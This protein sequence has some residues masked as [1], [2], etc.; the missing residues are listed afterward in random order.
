[1]IYG[2]LQL[3]PTL[4]LAPFL[5]YDDLQ[6]EKRV[7]TF[8]TLVRLQIWQKLVFEFSEDVGI[9]THVTDRRTAIPQ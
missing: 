6:A 3:Q 9:P 7:F 1:M 2:F 4:Y 5:K 8:S